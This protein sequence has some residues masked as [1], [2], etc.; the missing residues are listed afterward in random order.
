MLF[1]DLS[2]SDSCKME[3]QSSFDLMAKDVEHLFK[4]FSAIWDPCI[5]ESL[6]LICPPIFKLDYL[7]FDLV[8]IVLYIFWKLDL[9][10]IWT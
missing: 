2:H 5:E 10:Q 4:Y 7:D 1:I 6:F 3:S 8:S 9:C